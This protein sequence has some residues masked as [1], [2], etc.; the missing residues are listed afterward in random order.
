MS[1]FAEFESSKRPFKMRMRTFVP[2]TRTK[3]HLVYSAVK[4]TSAGTHHKFV[5]KCCVIN[6]LYYFVG[7]RRGGRLICGKSML[8]KFEV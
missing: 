3:V 5:T 4:N 8:K 7:A 2:K 6:A 1:L